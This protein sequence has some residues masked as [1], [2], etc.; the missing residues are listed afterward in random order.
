MQIEILTTAQDALQYDFSHCVAVV[1]DVFRATSVITTALHNGA[2][3][4]I[5]VATVDDAFATAQRLGRASVL[6]GGERNADPI[7]GFDLGNSPRLYNPE[8][9][10]GK[11]IILTTT[12]GT[13]AIHASMH[14]DAVY[15]ASMLNYKAV[16]ARLAQ[17]SPSRLVIVCS[18]TDGRPA[19]EDELCAARI[20]STLDANNPQSVDYASDE[21]LAVRLLASAFENTAA[22]PFSLSH[23]YATLVSK[24]Y[25]DD[26][27]ICISRDGDVDCLPVLSPDGILHKA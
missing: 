9:I 15:A 5:P 2:A 7:P 13:L 26:V 21:A 4:V 11:T 19:L 18:G 16:A 27:N 12:N 20:C 22:N 8:T 1:I 10:V 25:A 6:L 3:G 17:S 23:H 14:A 24:G